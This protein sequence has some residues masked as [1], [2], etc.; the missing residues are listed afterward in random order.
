MTFNYLRNLLQLIIFPASGWD[1]I[2]R[3]NKLHVE[4][5]AEY[6]RRTFIA[7]LLPLIAVASLAAL[8]GAAYHHSTTLAFAT[9]TAIVTFVKYFV[10]YYIAS[11]ALQMLLPKWTETTATAGTSPRKGSDQASMLTAYS[12]GY[13][14]LV[15]LLRNVLPVDLALLMFLPIY[16]ILILWK[17]R[18]VL[19]IAESKSGIYLTCTSLIILVVP[20]L[21]ERLLTSF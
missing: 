19:D 20:Y 9:T 11:F 10:S 3:D 2:E 21:I 6:M 13:L 18:E 5:L 17:A 8:L 15:T 1:D 12:L 14:V 16:V 4:G 7:G